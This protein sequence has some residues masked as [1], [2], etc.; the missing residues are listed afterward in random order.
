MKKE[1]EA[2]FRIRYGCG[3][4]HCRVVPDTIILPLANSK[5]T[6]AVVV[7]IVHHI[8]LLQAGGHFDSDNET[9]RHLK[10]LGALP[11][12]IYFL[13]TIPWRPSQQLRFKAVVCEY[14]LSLSINGANGG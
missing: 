13:H 1:F 8:K 14:Q 9:A 3:H 11:A 2:K 4:G 5:T 10:E 12:H 6:A 7:Y